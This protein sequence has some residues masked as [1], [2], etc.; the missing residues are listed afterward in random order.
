MSSSES[1]RGPRSPL[2]VLSYFVAAVALLISLA[3]TLRG[4]LWVYPLGGVSSVSVGCVAVLYVL[5]QYRFRSV[6]YS[7]T[8]SF[9]LAVLFANAFLQCYE[10]VY[11]VTF[12]VPLT[13]TEARSI[14]LW[15]IMI[16]PI[17]LVQEHLT[18]SRYF[19]LTLVVLAASWGVWILYGFPQY[20]LTGYSYPRFLV[21]SDPFHLSLW[22][23]FGT[24]ALL[25]AL[26]ATLLDPGAALD[27]FRRN[28]RARIV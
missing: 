27:A 2:V 19:A 24:K 1:G 12:G 22:L 21:S 5:G 25:A 3:L 6:G 17:L 28:R 18:F 9:V 14:I 26:F 16:S 15:L 23:N 13:G 10:L 7:E 4:Y 11:N 8:R 20:Y